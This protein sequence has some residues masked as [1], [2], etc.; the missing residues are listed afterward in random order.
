MGKLTVDLFG[1]MNHSAKPG[2]TGCHVSGKGGTVSSRMSCV[3]QPDVQIVGTEREEFWK[4]EMSDEVGVGG[5]ATGRA[6]KVRKEMIQ[7]ILTRELECRA[8][9]AVLSKI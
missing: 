6:V 1:L 4:E 7:K 2:F 5:G 8:R 9:K 3:S